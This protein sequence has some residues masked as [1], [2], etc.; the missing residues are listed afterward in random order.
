MKKSEATRL[1]ILQKAYELIYLN[2]YQTTSIDDIL[3]TTKVTKG[4][5]YYHFKN[6]DEMG[7]AIIKEILKPKFLTQI[8]RTFSLETNTIEALYIM[9]TMLLSDND[10]M[11]FEQ[12]CPLSNFIQEMTPKSTVFTEAL[13][14]LT[15]EWQKIIITNL[16]TGKKAG[17]INSKVQ[18][19][20]VAL[21]IISSYWGI[22]NFGRMES[23]N[24]AYRSYLKELK[25]Y[26]NSLQ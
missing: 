10:F 23:G 4:A 25:N 24:D 22:R 20:S 3:A 12:G 9:V 7:I 17:F 15:E 8:T 6:K 11:K 5:F 19:K 16:E 2:G 18:P 1:T 21:F 13:G 26:L 14:E